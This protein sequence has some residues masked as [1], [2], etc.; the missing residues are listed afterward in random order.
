[1]LSSL[2]KGVAL[3]MLWVFGALI[4]QAL[5]HGEHYAMP[6]SPKKRKAVPMLL[7]IKVRDTKLDMGVKELEQQVNQMALDIIELKMKEGI[8]NGYK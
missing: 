4:Y 3:I 5:L 6:I 2:A 7:E 1:M 8:P